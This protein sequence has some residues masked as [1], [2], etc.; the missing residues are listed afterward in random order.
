MK[1]IIENSKEFKILLS[2]FIIKFSTVEFYIS[3]LSHEID[4]IY[5]PHAKFE[6]AALKSLHNKREHIKKFIYENLQNLKPKWD[7]ISNN[8]NSIN[9]ERKHLVHGIGNPYIYG[10]NGYNIKNLTSFIP[11]QNTN[12]QFE[13]KDIEKINSEIDDIICKNGLGNEFYAEFKKELVDWYNLNLAERP[14]KFI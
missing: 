5:N 6:E 3:Y 4:K 2:E 10:M 11:K 12:R 1:D 9:N 7:I 8:I 13:Y 14:K